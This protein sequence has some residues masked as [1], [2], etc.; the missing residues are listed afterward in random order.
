MHSQGRN[1]SASGEANPACK[2]TDV[3]IE[4]I[5]TMKGKLSQAKIGALYGVAGS[6]VGR[7]HNNQTRSKTK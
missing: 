6:Y 7:I 4:E 5:R 2:L 3:Q 1:Y